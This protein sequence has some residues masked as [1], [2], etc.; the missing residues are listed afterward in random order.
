[1]FLGRDAGTGWVRGLRS[2]P[3]AFSRTRS[4]DTENHEYHRHTPF[5]PQ[6]PIAYAASSKVERRR[7]QSACGP[8]GRGDH[9]ETYYLISI[10]MRL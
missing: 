5:G 2:R 8:V 4:N 9:A 1:M 6:E 3:R 7:S 10:I